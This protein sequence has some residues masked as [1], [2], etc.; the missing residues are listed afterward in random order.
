MLAAAIALCAL[1]LAAAAGGAPPAGTL[2]YDELPDPM[3][4]GTYSVDRVDPL[5]L[6][7]EEFQE[8]NGEGK[9]A[10]GSN[11]TI[12]VPVRGVMYMP[13]G[14]PGKSPLLVFV[15]GN[16]GSCDAA[17]TPGAKAPG[18]PKCEEEGGFYKRN[19]EGY[20]YLGE[21]LAS[22][23]YTVVSL[24]QDEL[25]ARQDG[26]FGKGMHNRRYLIMALL[27]Q[28]KAS[29]EGN[30]PAGSNVGSLLEGKLDMT[31]IGLM[32]HSRGGDAVSSF[33]YYDMTR[34]A[35]ERYPLRGV[36]S[37][38]PV[39]YERHAPYGVPFMTVFGSCDGDVSNLQGARLYERS[40]YDTGDPYPRFQVV[41]V[42][43]NHDAYNTVWQADGDDANAN[44]AAC[45]PDV[46][47]GEVNTHNPHS[48]RLSGEA[49]SH[50]EAITKEN[51]TVIPG[52]TRPY[53]INDSSPAAKLDP[54]L[55]SRISGDPALMGD[56]EKLGLATMAAFFRR[57]VGGEG[58]FEPYL[59]GE[60]AA[61]ADPSVPVDACPTSEA[62]VRIPCIDRVADSYTAPPAE[63]ED[64]LRPDT[65]HPTTMDALGT[66]I[67]ASG[68]KNPYPAGG[69]VQPRPAT[70]RNGIDWCDPDPRQTIP[71]QLKEGPL[72]TATKPCPNPAPNALGGQAKGGP[73]ER[74][75]R[76]NAPVNG[77]YGRQLSLAW[78]GPATMGLPIP[79]ADGNVSGYRALY[80]AAAVNFFDKRNPPRGEEGE[81]NPEAAPQNFTVAVKDAEGHEATVEAGDPR[82]GTAL[83][84]TL[85]STSFRVHVILRDLRV[86]LADFAEQGVD[87][88]KLR[89]LELR[90]GGAGMPRSGSIQLADVRFQQPASGYS[91][92]LL[93]TTT[94]DAGP[95]E[96][97]PTSGPNPV[98]EMEAGVHPRADGSYEIPAA[99]KVPGANVWTVDDDGVQCPN[100]EFEHI[101]EAVEYASPWDTIVVCPGV[102]AEQSKP[103][104]STANPVAENAINGLTITKPLKIVGAGAGLVTI[105]PATANSSLAGA[106]ANLRDGG[107]NVI[108]VSRQSLGS[109]EY[110]ED[111][112]DIS[113]VTIESAKTSV[114]A[115]VAFF[116]SSGRISDSV[117][118]PLKATT[119]NGWG[120]VETN[121]LLGAGVGSAER[122]V[123][124]EDSTIKGYGAGGVLFDGSKG[125]LDGA[126]TNTERSG[127]NQVGYVFDSTI[128]GS[129]GGSTVA[130][131]G[132]AYRSGARGEVT[133]SAV[134]KNHST[135]A[136]GN[137][138]GVL[139]ADSG[140]V[141]VEGSLI[142]ENGAKGFGLFNGD[143]TA[144][145]VSTG[146]PVEA[147]GNWWG[148]GGAPVEGET[149]LGPPDAEGVSGSGSVTF[150][151]VAGG[152]PVI[153]PVPGSLPD[154]APVGALVEPGD[155]EAVESGEPV[156]P[157]VFAE[158][159]YGVKSVSLTA[160]GDPVET[161]AA[162]P[163]VF[164][165]TPTPAEIGASVHLEA[166]ITDSSGQVTTSEV[167]VPVVKS[168]AEAAS[169]KA[170]EEG[171]K[172]AEE[173]VKEGEE[174]AATEAA[175]KA[176]AEKAE[177]DRKA[178]E[179]KAEGDVKSAEAKAEAAEKEAKAAKEEAENAKL[180]SQPLSTGKT[181][182][183]TKKG[184]A[185]LTVT[186]P[187]PGS[188]VVIGA[189]VTK[190][191]G[192]PTAPGP[193]EVLIKAKG[194]ALKTL[195]AKGKVTVKVSITLTGPDGTKQATATVTLVK[196]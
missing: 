114:D 39:D 82:Y 142:A 169:E 177:A 57:Y 23:G 140:V 49:G 63:R 130:Q 151:P 131:T 43:G 162:A 45:G 185:R 46:T 73:E 84:Q 107:G 154:A 69:G 158:D 14:K 62:G 32:G 116:N 93:D 102:Y 8:P 125:G 161:I 118:G 109:T 122:Q 30:P 53:K 34:P 174:K 35:G 188:L 24:D 164:S 196:K 77:S 98:A 155:G 171:Q 186:V 152:V 65:E 11:S 111:F 103:V 68:F 121:S 137:S 25:M 150:D 100:A 170:A 96:G 64:V 6:G 13:E 80:M 33:I 1:A 193:V 86:P 173:E 149:V 168:T 99:T 157:V 26:N 113:G 27:D 55:N 41:Q 20:A 71:S 58:A 108:T 172:V 4:R 74:E 18:G 189:G 91:N 85:G 51:G 31:R 115:G 90:F 133:G 2:K 16:H 135:T 70:T 182:K 166:T 97:P 52:A 87:L 48:I 76:E 145:A 94:P 156:A 117:V 17:E 123:T 120:V 59:T 184:T 175:T 72:P 75:P 81:W 119:G 67:E 106:T 183:D 79:A 163:Y 15:H 3:Q 60:L 187:T 42:G 134:V 144:G 165:W 126:A 148:T 36:I 127:L 176:A 88:S 181:V 178:A 19:D 95:A 10:E 44:D 40:Q 89:R 110:D 38:A 194:R 9:K 124:I 78:E 138:Y 83:Q 167:T 195:D 92:V 50:F 190:V 66:G 7:T 146:A 129:G 143:A 5:I 21:N 47:G 28:L 105:K 153:P 191:S 136:T 159:D 29:T 61:E 56:Q 160:D 101:Q 54:T 112:V 179:A 180:A 139:A 141:T 22:W 147:T 128:E 12:K 132:I 192:N 104:N 37:L